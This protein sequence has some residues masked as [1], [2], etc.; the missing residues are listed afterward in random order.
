M[1]HNAFTFSMVIGGEQMAHTKSALKRIRQDKKRNLR[2]QSVKSTV[3]TATR[4]FREALEEDD[5]A[6]AQTSLRA[7]SKTLCQAATK[8]VVR[9]QTAAR[10]ISRLAKAAHKSLAAAK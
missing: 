2:N 6:K 3:R 1:V 5:A 4:A 10:R 7:A 9:K 8:G